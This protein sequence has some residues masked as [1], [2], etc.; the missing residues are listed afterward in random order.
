MVGPLHWQQLLHKAVAADGFAWRKTNELK[1]N[2]GSSCC[3]RA[4]G[5]CGHRHHLPER[6]W[7][8]AEKLAAAATNAMGLSETISRSFGRIG[9]TLVYRQHLEKHPVQVKQSAAPC[10]CR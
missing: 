7:A 2:I 9:P 8:Q 6:Q 3:K 4:G 1:R 10:S 5:T